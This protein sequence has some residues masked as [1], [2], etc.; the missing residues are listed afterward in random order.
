MKGKS[1]TEQWVTC[2]YFACVG[3]SVRSVFSI[4][5]NPSSLTGNLVF[6]H[7]IHY[8]HISY[9]EA[10]VVPEQLALGQSGGAL[11]I[12]KTIPMESAQQS[13]VMRPG[14]KSH[15]WAAGCHRC[16]T[17]KPA[18]FASRQVLHEA[19]NQPLH[20][21]GQFTDKGSH[22]ILVK[23]PSLTCSSLYIHPLWQHINSSLHHSVPVFWKS[24][25][26]FFLPPMFWW[27]KYWDK[28]K[29]CYPWLVENN[30]RCVVEF[31]ICCTESLSH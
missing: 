11:L 23:S 7:L 20:A 22:C 18:H 8:W 2:I 25:Y 3:V 10:A 1:K 21:A 29:W 13:L 28:M 9:R 6:F 31:A 14:A 15:R 24:T 30:A 19:L 5:V 12:R 4:C 26:F 16:C 27:W 17:W